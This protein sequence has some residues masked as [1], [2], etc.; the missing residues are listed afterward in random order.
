[1]TN[2]KSAFQSLEETSM[3][4]WDLEKVRNVTVLASTPQTKVTREVTG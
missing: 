1:M 2:N 3:L 4:S